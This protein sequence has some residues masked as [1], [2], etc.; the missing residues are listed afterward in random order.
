MIA[1]I[2][3]HHIYRTR[4]GEACKVVGI[5]GDT[6]LFISETHSPRIVE[7][8]PFNLFAVCVIEEVPGQ[9]VVSSPA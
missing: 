4:S 2:L 6:I 8:M 5:L 1:T 7:E 9:P 3:P